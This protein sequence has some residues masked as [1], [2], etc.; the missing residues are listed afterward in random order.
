M[1][2]KTTAL[3][4]TLP[5]LSA[6]KLSFAAQ[7][8]HAVTDGPDNAA[9]WM[10]EN[11]SSLFTKESKPDVCRIVSVSSTSALA[12]CLIA[13]ALCEHFKKVELTA[14]HASPGYCAHQEA[15]CKDTATQDLINDGRLVLQTNRPGELMT[16]SSKFDI[17]LFYRSLVGLAS[18][19][20]AVIQTMEQL[21][22][23]HGS[24]VVMHDS[25]D[26]FRAVRKA[27]EEFLP[28]EAVSV[29]SIPSAWH[30]TRMI[31]ATAG[32]Q[33][34]VQNCGTISTHL[35]TDAWRSGNN[36]D[37][38]S[39]R[40]GSNLEG[41]DPQVIEC[42]L[43][44][45]AVCGILPEVRREK[46]EHVQDVAAKFTESVEVIVIQHPGHPCV[47]DGKR[48]PT[49]SDPCWPNGVG[50]PPFIN[51]GYEQWLQ[52]R[53]EWNRPRGARRAPPAPRPASCDPPALARPQTRAVHS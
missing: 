18:P 49:A 29:S 11:L 52:V 21:L 37:G 35:N 1:D 15:A 50:N 45:L 32:G 26:T 20:G 40:L 25:M 42:L 48:S 38:L 19:G 34:V 3:Q 7:A 23:E 8:Y 12:D 10:R 17:V 5:V 39:F 47:A 6:E 44:I 9:K 41:Q 27:C 22:D 24:V 14:E 4:K 46:S 28:E 13:V 51:V 2:W 33:C 30:L 31:E 43:G 16:L 36:L 53:E